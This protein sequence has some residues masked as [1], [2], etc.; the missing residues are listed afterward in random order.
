MMHVKRCLLWSW[1]CQGSAT[2]AWAPTSK[3]IPPPTGTYNVGVKKLE[4]NYTN[5]GDPIAPGNVTTSFIA[6]AWYP[7]LDE[8]TNAPE[9]YLDPATASLWEI[10]YNQS[11]GTLSSLT[12]TL[13]R[14]G[15]PISNTSFPTLIFGPGGVGPPCEIYTIL[16]SELAS[17]GYRVF[18]LD[19]PYEQ[20]FVRYPNGTGLYGLPVLFDAYTLDFLAALQTIRIKEI[21]AFIDNIPTT[22]AEQLGTAVNATHIGALGHSLGGAA[23]LGAMIADGRIASGINMDGEFWGALAANDSSVDVGK[24]RPVLLLG[25]GIH[26]P[27]PQDNATVDQTWFTF[28]AQQTAWWRELIVENALHHDYDDEAFW[29]EIADFRDYD[30]S[31]GTINGY[32]QVNITRTFVRTFFDY[33]LL[34]L[35]SEIFDGSSPAWSDVTFAGG[36]DGSQ[37]S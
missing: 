36:S 3:T 34:G 28:P 35:S 10:A 8:C 33:A 6:T 5:T 30:A 29:K 1:L 26:D 27:Q 4:I 7:T 11:A 24:G 2:L 15:S 9:P 19:H 37:E 21:S 32:R 17:R 31:I 22:V 18:G 12:S 25:S 23:A 14:D 13:V 20:P 16:A